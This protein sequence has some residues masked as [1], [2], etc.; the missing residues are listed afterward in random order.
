MN[1]SIPPLSTSNQRRIP[2]DATHRQ[3]E[4]WEQRDAFKLER[5]KRF[6]DPMNQKNDLEYELRTTNWI[7][8]KVRNSEIY[9]QNL[10]AAMCNNEFVR[11]DDVWNILKEEYWGVSWRTAGGIIADMREEGDYMDWYC[12]GISQPNTGNVSESVV[13]QEIKDDL[14]QLGWVVIH[15]NETL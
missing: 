1:S 14:R 8:Q 4:I 15:D 5:D 2:L 13:T 10:Y 3:Q 9:A 12:S 11:I 6:N 7:L